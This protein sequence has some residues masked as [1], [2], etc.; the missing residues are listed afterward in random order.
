MRRA[1]MGLVLAGWGG[2]LGPAAA[3]QLDDP[4]LAMVPRTAA[5]AA[6]IAGATA[7][8]G[9]FSKPE[10]SENRPA[11]AATV[12]PRATTDAFSQP[13]ANLTPAEVADFNLGNGLFTK[14][15]V[16]APA[17]TRASDGLGPL[18]NARSCQTCHVKDGRGHPPLNAK[19]KAVSI[20]LRLSV[21]DPAPADNGIADYLASLPDPVYGN[22]LQDFAG[23]GQGAE[24]HLGVSYA[25][26]AV[27]LAGGESASL[28]APTYRADDLGYG[29]LAQGAMLSPR[30]A[31]PMIGLGLLEA[32]PAA[33]I[34]AHA[35]PDDANHDGISGRPNI[36]I[37]AAFGTPMLGRFGLKAGQP[38]VREQSAAAFSG[39]MGLSSPLHPEGW[40]DCTAM[41]D[42]CRSAP[43][44]ASATDGLEVPAKGMDLVTFYARNLGV[45]G[46]RDAADPQV[47]RGKAVFY[48]AGCPAC[49][50]AKFVTGRLQDGSAQSFQLIWPFSDL[51]LHDMGEGLADHRPEGRATGTEWRTA[52][53]WGIGLT[54]TVA[55]TGFYLHDGRARS[56]LEAILW[57]GGEA[58]AARDQVVAMP[59]ADRA[60]LIRYLGSL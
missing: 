6:R 19:D 45:P 35:D 30:M 5:E 46:R 11:G 42:A 3:Q 15:W 2:L 9:D 55:G 14:I 25:E 59:P 28:R 33:D 37:S 20:F 27:P 54:E 41:Q 16:A 48:Q 17:S 56:L 12:R 8:T 58:E 39:D 51:L 21:P 32:I 60:A 4:H 53:L 24:Y 7:L 22:Q 38:T 47:L 43:D 34:L 44:G 49:H 1:W 50:I 31:P 26:I 13:S 18:Y 29:P 36:G 40:G 52:P 10:A 57:H 23:P